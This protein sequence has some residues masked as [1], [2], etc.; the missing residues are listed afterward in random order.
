LAAVHVHTY[1]PPQW[2]FVYYPGAVSRVHVLP[3]K[4]RP[5]LRGRVH[6][7]LGKTPTI[8]HRHVARP[9]ISTVGSPIY[10]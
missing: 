10:R 9:R 2:P 6:R 3:H 1:Q 4:P 7:P 5:P 8:T